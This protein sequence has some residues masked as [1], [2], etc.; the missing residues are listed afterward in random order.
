[1][2]NIVIEAIDRIYRKYDHDFFRSSCKE[3]F[4][5]PLELKNYI[6]SQ[7]LALIDMFDNECPS[8]T[9]YI[10]FKDYIKG[11][12]KVS[13]KTMLQVSKITPLFY[14]QHEFSVENKD[15]NSMT[16][17]L[18]GFDEQPYNKGQA[19][20]HDRICASL[21]E[22]RYIQLAYSEANEVISDLNMPEDVTV[23]GPQVT[24]ESLLF[25]DVFDICNKE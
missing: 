8:R 19:E 23:F 16:S 15:E 25:R 9:W 7:G 21:G 12:F 22:K 13:Y 18:D 2:I 11:E 20:L 3:N 24:V 17:E 5:L 14:V 6:E 10:S 1:M 4:E